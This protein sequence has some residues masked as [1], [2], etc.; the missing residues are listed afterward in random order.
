MLVNLQTDTSIVS[1]F[2]SVCVCVCVCV[3]VGLLQMV[4]LALTGPFQKYM[5]N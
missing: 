4:S 5:F 2:L 3:C 1:E